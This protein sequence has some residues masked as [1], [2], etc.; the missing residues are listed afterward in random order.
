MEG[1]AALSCPQDILNLK[2]PHSSK[3]LISCWF[4]FCPSP[5]AH[6]CILRQKVSDVFFSKYSMCVIYMKK[7]NMNHEVIFYTEEEMSHIAR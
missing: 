2:K 5:P 3:V 6:A 1:S 7:K 4:D